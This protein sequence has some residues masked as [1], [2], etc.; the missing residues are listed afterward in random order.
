MASFGDGYRHHVTGLIHDQKGFPTQ[1][2]AE[3]AAFM[4][5]QFRKITN[6]FDE[7]LKTR[8]F[9]LEDAEIAVIAYGSVSRSALS[10]VKEARNNGIKAGFLQ[11]LTLFPFP[12][13][14][15]MNVV[16][17]CKAVIVPEMNIGQISREVKRVNNFPCRVVKVNRVDG[18]FIAP[19]E[20]YHELMK[21][22]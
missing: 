22:H 18:Q 17:Q 8:A 1:K 12:K 2:P 20:I 19:H 4:D 13:S 15:V 16:R 6:G 3:I 9:M 7:I 11:L 5:R 14:H 21:I 10:A